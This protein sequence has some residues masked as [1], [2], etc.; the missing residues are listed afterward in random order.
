MKP[1]KL[2]LILMLLPML[3]F[4]QSDL[5]WDPYRTPPWEDRVPTLNETY[6][7]YGQH[8]TRDTYLTFGGTYVLSGLVSTQVEKWSGNFFL[9]LLASTLVS[10]GIGYYK[11]VVFDREWNTAFSHD[12]ILY[13]DTVAGALGGITGSFT[14]TIDVE[15]LLYG[16]GKISFSNKTKYNQTRFKRG[17]RTFLGLFKKK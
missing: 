5:P 14:L 9:G 7:Q 15:D 17:R 8:V 1:T 4:S 16:G 6:E 3:G 13:N 11:D 12:R 10:S 2:L